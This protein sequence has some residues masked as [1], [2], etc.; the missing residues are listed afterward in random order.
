VILLDFQFACM[1]SLAAQAFLQAAYAHPRSSC[2]QDFKAH[3]WSQRNGPQVTSAGF[4]TLLKTKAAV[5]RDRGRPFSRVRAAGG[6]GEVVPPP[7]SAKPAEQKDKRAR[8]RS[9]DS[10]ELSIWNEDDFLWPSER[11]KSVNFVGDWPALDEV[12][13]SVRVRSETDMEVDVFCTEEDQTVA[14]LHSAWDLRTQVPLAVVLSYVRESQPA[15]ASLSASDPF[16]EHTLVPFP[17][18]FDRTRAQRGGYLESLPLKAAP[19]K[20]SKKRPSSSGSGPAAT[21]ALTTPSVGTGLAV[22]GGEGNILT[23]KRR[24]S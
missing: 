8:S 18:K 2:M 5:E 15:F 17:R 19:P 21:A 7:R 14:R 4:D 24:R 9:L 16:Q 20:P 1:L 6:P 12:G 11:N 22:V 3:H 23:Y 13:T 10:D